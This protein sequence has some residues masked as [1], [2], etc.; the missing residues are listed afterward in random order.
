MNRNLDGCYFRVCRNGKW[1][2][3][4]FTD[5]TK[6]E[7]EQVANVDG[8]RP[9]EW[10]KTLAYHLADTIQQIGNELDIVCED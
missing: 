4:C 2:T 5:L 6:E 9:A 3:H 7:R 1:E 8:G 10:W